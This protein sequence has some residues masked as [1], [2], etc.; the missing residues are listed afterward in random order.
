MHA[1]ASLWA[2]H[3]MRKNITD[4][5]KRSHSHWL[6]K[7]SL[8]NHWK[9]KIMRKSVRQTLKPLCLNVK[10]NLWEIFLGNTDCMFLDTIDGLRLLLLL[11]IIYCNCWRSLLKVFSGVLL[12][13]LPCRYPAEIYQKRLYFKIP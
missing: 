7:S 12:P 9:E 5:R 10:E 2:F 1:E 13:F 8:Q 3:S 11:F 6:I 4:F